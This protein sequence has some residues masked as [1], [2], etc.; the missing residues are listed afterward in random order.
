MYLL[1]FFFR[2]ILTE[3]AFFHALQSAIMA[4]MTVYIE[5]AFVENF[6][7]DLLLLYLAILVTR[8]KTRWWRLLLASGVGAAV[9]IVFPLLSLPPW[10]SYLVKGLS[11]GVVALVASPKWG[12]ACVLTVVSFFALTF[13]YGGMLTAVYSYLKIEYVAGNGYLVERAPVSL[14]LC[15]GIAF[16]LIVGW[17]ARAFYRYRKAKRCV[18]ECTVNTGEK[19]VRWQGFLDSGNLLTFRGSPVC[20]VS[21]TA[22]FALFGK[23]A[24]SAGRVEIATVNG[25]RSSPVFAVKS[26]CVGSRE[27]GNVYFTVGDVGKAYQIILHSSMIGEREER[28]EAHK[29]VTGLAEKHGGR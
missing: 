18:T 9:A 14:V 8:Q 4:N 29:T 5:Y 23:G 2:H 11:G 6:L 7:L 20:V 15:G 13:L 25:S 26:V 28:H 12:K 22:I 27:Y 3:Y 16:F 21:A 17:G 1:F 10:A 24:V 19:C